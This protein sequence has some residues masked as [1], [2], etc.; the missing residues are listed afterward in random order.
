[1]T[2]L[3][4]GEKQVTTPGEG[5]FWVAPNAALIG[6][7]RLAEDV[8]VWFSTVIRGDNE[9]VHIGPRS[10]VQDGC[11]LHTDPGFPMHIEADVTIGH[12]VMLH[13]CT[14]GAGSLIG[15]GSVILNGAVVGEQCLVGAR[16][17]I[18][19]GKKIP[20]RSVVMGSPAKVVREVTDEDLALLKR[21]AENYVRHWRRYAREM[22]AD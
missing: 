2:L 22:S 11:V 18:T 20:P 4:L 21:A 8:S 16:A 9:P 10:N 14:V 6:D 17:L 13:G 3:R 1:M 7:V 15:I 19:E 12:M 5:R